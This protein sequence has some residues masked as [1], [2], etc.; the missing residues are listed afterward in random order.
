MAEHRGGSGNFAE[1]RERAS[2]AGRKGGKVSGGNFK[3]DPQRASL[4]G[5]KG[6]RNS[7]GSRSKTEEH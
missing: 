7:R 5:E 4:A 3:N 1:N 6:G 2:E